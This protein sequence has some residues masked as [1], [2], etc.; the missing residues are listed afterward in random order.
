M[1]AQKG[2]VRRGLGKF[3][4]GEPATRKNSASIRR[5][6]YD[7]IDREFQRSPA[8]AARQLTRALDTAEDKRA[9]RKGFSEHTTY[10][11]QRDQ[12]TISFNELDSL[13]LYYGVPLAL[14][15][16]FTRARSEMTNFDKTRAL[17]T[18][19]AFR[20]AVRLLEETVSGRSGKEDG[21]LS[22]SDFETIRDRFREHFG[23]PQQR[24]L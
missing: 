10:R 21:S 23:D 4:P 1:A 15:V 11:L 14:V 24:L 3:D 20:E 12:K 19:G 7:L 8:E 6:V 16:I 2:D 22:H 18:L 13:G 17:R 9:Y 5:F